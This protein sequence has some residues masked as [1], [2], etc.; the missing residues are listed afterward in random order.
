VNCFYTISCLGVTKL[1]P[2]FAL[3]LILKKVKSY[4]RH[5][6]HFLFSAVAHSAQEIRPSEE[7]VK[8]LTGSEPVN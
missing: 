4:R 6:P 5:K 3:S 8:L 7:A 1:F 2:P